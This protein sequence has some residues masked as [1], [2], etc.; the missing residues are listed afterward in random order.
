LDP[1]KLRKPKFTPGLSDPFDTEPDLG[2]VG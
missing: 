2:T 1:E